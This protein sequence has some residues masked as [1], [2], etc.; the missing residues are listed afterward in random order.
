MCNCWE[1]HFLNC[2]SGCFSCGTRCLLGSSLF[3]FHELICRHHS[4]TK[5]LCP[6]FQWQAIKGVSEVGLLSVSFHCGALRRCCWYI[7]VRSYVHLESLQAA[8]THSPPPVQKSTTGVSNNKSSLSFNIRCRILHDNGQFEKTACQ[9][10]RLMILP[11]R[12]KH[13][14]GT[15]SGTICHTI[16]TKASSNCPRK[17]KNTS[18]LSRPA[19]SFFKAS[20]KTGRPFSSTRS[21]GLRPHLLQV[22]L[23]WQFLA[24]FSKAFQPLL[25]TLTISIIFNGL[26]E[27][28]RLSKK[29]TPNDL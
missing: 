22:R 24:G 3:F 20:F 13:A 10:C 12:T 28:L 19:T 18:K 2:S 21:A 23:Q 8:E 4:F 6:G 25:L 29:R 15:A 17:E 9:D 16:S 27:I 14:S 1:L 11:V 5:C 7:D 26:S